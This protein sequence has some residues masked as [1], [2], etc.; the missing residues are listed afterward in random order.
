M[1]KFVTIKS[2]KND[3]KMKNLFFTWIFI[4][5]IWLL[6]HFTIIFFF[7]IVLESILLVWIFLA[8][9]NLVALLIDIP[10]WVLQKYLHP[11]TLLAISN[12]LMLIV[13][14]IIFKFTFFKEIELL[15][16]WTENDIEKTIS[17]LWMFLNSWL[18]FILLIISRI[19]YWFIKEIYDVTAL[20]YIF[21]NS[22]PSE[23]AKYISKYNIHFGIWAVIW[24]IFS[25]I[26]LAINLKIGV[27]IFIT[28]IILFYYFIWKYF[29]NIEQT[30]DFEDIKNIRIDN[31]KD[32]LAKNV[33]NVVEKI[34]TKTLI[35][36][37]KKSKL[38]LLKPI[39][40][41]KN[42][43]FNDVV[44]SS[45][46]N[47]KRFKNIIFS[48]PLNLALIWLIM[49]ILQYGFWDTF[50]STFQIDFLD[51]VIDINKD[52]MIIKQTWW[53]INWYLILVLLVI[54]A[55]LL[56]DFFINLSKKIWVFN[57]LMIWTI[58]SRISMF[59]F[60]ISDNF[61][62]VILFWLLNSVWYAA[63]MPI[64]QSSFSEK[65]NINYAQKY[66]LK[67]IDTT[68][69]AGPLKIL[70]NLANVMWLILWSLIVSLVWFNS[71]F[72][73]FSLTLL[74]TFIFSFLN[75]NKFNK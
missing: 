28:I 12:T 10:V 55:F 35:E 1:V 46:E 26:L 34:N 64:A 73:F 31:Y 63:S 38:I 25:W 17:Y 70:L 75:K 7:W 4:W 42:I 68:I 67:Q 8:I 6:F 50:V 69:S 27:F 14:L 3:I 71:F 45:I 18:N 11:R 5:F 2:E 22:T 49:I 57:V 15:Y 65:Y 51:K 13:I 48:T 54:P 56:Q 32:I 20:S 24:V 40:I 44:K 39:E 62:W 53:L 36:L 9:W 59:C 72:I 19:L 47:I 58:I 61:Y 16:I 60:W 23:Y 33:N 30:I 37:S 21:N 43:D 41:R 29:D 52:T 66:N 74:F